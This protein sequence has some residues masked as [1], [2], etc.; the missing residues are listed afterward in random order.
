VRLYELTE[1]Y[2][3][4]LELAQDCEPGDAALAAALGDTGEALEQ[5]CIGIGKVLAQLDAD[6]AACA[7]E[8]ERL[9]VKAQR[10]ARNADNLRAYVLHSMTTRGIEKIKAET[11]EFR[12]VLNPERVEVDSIEL[13]PAEYRKT[14][15]VETTTVDKR[16]VLKAYDGGAGEVVPGCRIERGQRL[17]I[18]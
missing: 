11:F 9:S 3:R 5:K 6:A 7:T 12:V 15:V 17:A 18:K 14:K 13:V 16:A 10:F 1:S 8:A 2:S 4:L